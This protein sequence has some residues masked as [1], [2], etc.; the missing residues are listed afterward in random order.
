M[1]LNWPALILTTALHHFDKMVQAEAV[2]HMK[3]SVNKQV[4]GHSV[5]RYRITKGIEGI[6]WGLPKDCYSFVK[7]PPPLGFTRQHRPDYISTSSL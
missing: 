4:F 6:P 7:P 1:I 3:K 2:H 5:S